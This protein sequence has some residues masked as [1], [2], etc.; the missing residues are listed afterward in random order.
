MV[1]DGERDAS[2]RAIEA[3]IDTMLEAGWVDEVRALLDRWPASAR[4]FG[5]VGYAQIVAH[6]LR[7]VPLDDTRKAIRKATRT[8]A[9]RQ[10]T[11]FKNEPGVAWRTEHGALTGPAGLER[12]TQWLATR[13]IGA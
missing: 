13:D 3:R 12:V 5:S 9:R 8:Y 11:W 7:Q 10:R 6:V 2:D 4:A 1:L